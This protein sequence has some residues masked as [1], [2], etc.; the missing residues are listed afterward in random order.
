MGDGDFEKFL[1]AV[2]SGDR[3]TATDL[4]RQYEPYIR[5]VIHVRLADRRVRHVVESMD[6][7]QSVMAD[8]FATAEPDRFKFETPDDVRRLLV[9]MAL[10]KLRNW[11]RHESRRE[12]AFPDEWDPV[13][14]D[15]TPS[16]LAVAQEEIDLIKSRLPKKEARLFDLHRIQGRSWEEIARDLGEKPDALRMRLMR[17]VARVLVE[18]NGSDPGHAK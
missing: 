2:R 8:F 10:N 14:N 13:T 16:R 7:C 9:T 4:V 18:R 3:R 1:A 17:A 6:I 5:R 12:E 11:A 15:P